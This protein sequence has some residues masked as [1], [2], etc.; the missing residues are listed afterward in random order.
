MLSCEQSQ[1]YDLQKLSAQLETTACLG[2]ISRLYSPSTFIVGH[3]ELVHIFLVIYCTIWSDH[4]GIKII[5]DAGIPL[6][7][8]TFGNTVIMDTCGN[9]WLYPGPSPYWWWS[10]MISIIV[11]IA[12]SI[13]IMALLVTS[14]RI[15]FYHSCNRPALNPKQQYQFHPISMMKSTWQVQLHHFHPKKTSLPGSA[16]RPAQNAAAPAPAPPAQAAPAADAAAGAAVEVAVPPPEAPRAAEPLEELVE[17][18][19][20]ALDRWC[21][22]VW[23]AMDPINIPP[24]NVS[25]NLPAPLGSYG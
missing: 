4:E 20:P 23:C 10:P 11:R 16:P 24:I 6:Q 7:L 9:H 8:A 2:S 3:T 12:H 21:C 14:C 15:Q 5:E 17:S 22:Y 18:E 25:I 19:A 13:S 1:L